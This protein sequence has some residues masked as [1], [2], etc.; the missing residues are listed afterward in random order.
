M[1][2]RGRRAA[3]QRRHDVGAAFTRLSKSPVLD[4]FGSDGAY[5]GTVRGMQLPVGRQPQGELLVPREDP[6]SGGTVLLRMRVKR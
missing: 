5:V 3:L 2:V 4:V 1:P 6:E